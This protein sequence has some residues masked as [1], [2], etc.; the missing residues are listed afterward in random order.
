MFSLIIQE[1]VYMSTWR[2]IAILITAWLLYHVVPCRPIVRIAPN[3]YSLD[4]PE[5][6]KIIYGHGT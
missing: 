2:I 6:A 3:Q 4:N 1:V 5:A